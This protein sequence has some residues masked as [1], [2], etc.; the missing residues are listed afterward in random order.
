MLWL[1]LFKFSLDISLASTYRTGLNLIP[2][3]DASQHDLREMIANFIVF[4]PFGLLL[5]TNL[6]RSTFW[7]K[8]AL[9]CIFSVTAEMIQLIFAIGTA[10]ITDVITNSTGGLLG[11][12]VYSFISMFVHGRKLDRCIVVTGAVLLVMLLG[13]LFSGRLTFQAAPGAKAALSQSAAAKDLRLT[14]PANGAAAIG[15][16]EDGVLARSSGTEKQRPMA[17]MAKVVTAIAILEKQPLML[18]QPGQTYTLTAKDVANYRKE[19]ARDGSAVPVYEGMVLS[20]YDAL[21][22]MLLASANNIADTLVE[23]VFGS[24]Q[25]YL[26]YAQ[27][28]LHSKGFSQ[29]VITDAS[30]F[31]S[32]TVSTPSELVALGI[33][34]L[35]N[36]VIAE[37]V[38][39][40]QAQIQDVG[41]I[42]NTNQ[43]L[44]TN[45][46][47]GIKT[48]TTDEAGS[49]LLFAA[50]YDGKDGKKVTVVGVVMGGKNAAGMFSDSEELLASAKQSLGLTGGQSSGNDDTVQSRPPR[51][52]EPGG[53]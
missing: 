49:C 23:K 1:I 22:M 33:E 29:T 40:P 36:P 6:K 53:L 48:G 19:T 15:T 11:L 43:L 24:K 39:K 20:Q 25:A 21:Q 5:G 7:W 30:G 27:N 34:A 2:F 10:D 4:I 26:A 35:G 18:K 42:S 9:I 16:V 47:I 37:I 52:R 12:L 17:S 8:L 41:Y 14:W 3:A 51:L 45:G 46:V 31:S 38:A 28:M 13:I 50:Q 32:K 44:G